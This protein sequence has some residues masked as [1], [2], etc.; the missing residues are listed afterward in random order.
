MFRIKVAAH[1]ESRMWAT[2][3]I[4]GTQFLSHRDVG[5]PEGLLEDIWPDDAECSLSGN[6]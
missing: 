5:P 2:G 3:L 1:S 6:N 4:S